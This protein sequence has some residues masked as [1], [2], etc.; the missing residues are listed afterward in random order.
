MLECLEMSFGLKFRVCWKDRELNR[1]KLGGG[2]W[3]YL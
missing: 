1:W 2:S 3:L